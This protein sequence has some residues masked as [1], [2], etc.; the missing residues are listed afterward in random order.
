MENKITTVIVDD[1]LLARKGLSIRLEQF[2]QIEVVSQAGDGEQAIEDILTHKPMLVF[3]DIQMPGMSGFEVL[4]KLQS[5]LPKDE[6]PIVV[7]VT[8]FDQYALQAFEVHALDYLLKPVNDDRL[9]ECMDKIM[10]TIN[11][12]NQMHNQDK[13]V[14]LMS[15]LTGTDSHQILQQLAEGSDIEINE[16]SD[17]ISVKDIGETTRIPVSDVIWIDA[18]GDYMCVHCADGETHILRKTMKQ[19]EQELDPNRFIRVHRS[20]IV[21]NAEVAKVLTL[22]SGEYV[23]QLTN[24]HE[25]RVSRSYRDKVREKLL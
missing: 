20:V 2:P 24:K 11:N 22:S 13:L 7:F 21:N 19:L 23:I 4:A 15:K 5:L 10:Q 12:Q 9:S 1:E 14:S 16:Y 17:F 25:I 3:L 6:W 18:A 8:A